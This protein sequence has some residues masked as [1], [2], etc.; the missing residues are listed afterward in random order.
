MDLLNV[1]KFLV[2]KTKT[3]DQG[4]QLLSTRIHGNENQ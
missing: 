1:S 3:S 2:Y 4:A